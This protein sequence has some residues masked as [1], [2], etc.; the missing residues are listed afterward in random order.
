MRTF[1]RPADRTRRGRADVVSYT[2]ELGRGS[3]ILCDDLPIRLE[4]PGA[5]AEALLEREAAA[6]SAEPPPAASRWRTALERYFAGERLDFDLDVTAFAAA[7]GCTDFELAVYRALAGVA[8]GEVV[9][10]RDLAVAAGRPN[11]YRAAG[12]VMA[13]NPLPVILPCHR[14]VHNDGR[15][16]LYGNDP[17]W[18]E[19]LLALEGVA[20]IEGRLA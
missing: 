16:G 8:Y 15:L 12:S 14:V 19:R 6:A 7:H 1:T 5:G 20:L 9:S 13:R 2:T 10:Y 11:A 17:A 4:L 3:V 18:K